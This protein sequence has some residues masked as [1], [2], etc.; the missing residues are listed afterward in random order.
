MSNDPDWA[1]YRTLLSVLDGG[2]LSAAARALGLTQPTVARHID[3]LEAALGADLFVRS[4][5]GLEPTDLAHAL[6]P[7]AQTMATTAGA[8]LRTASGT[9]GAVVGTVRISASDV[10]GVEY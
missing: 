10:V 9:I 2:S 8:L 3:A 6:R 1:H 4:Q 5:R 7:H